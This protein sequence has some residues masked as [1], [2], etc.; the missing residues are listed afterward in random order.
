MRHDTRSRERRRA[1]AP[2]CITRRSRSQAEICTE[3]MY[4][5]EWRITLTLMRPASWSHADLP[6]G[7]AAQESVQPLLQK[8][9]ISLKTQINLIT[10]PVSARMRGAS[11][12]SRLLGWDAVDA[13]APGAQPRSQGGSM[14]PVSG[15]KARQTATLKIA[16]P[17]AV[18]SVRP[19]RWP[20]RTNFA[21]CADARIGETVI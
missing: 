18:E 15:S 5:T 3:L 6:D 16:E 19:A 13:R 14:R 1:D 7:R 17:P 12:S 4:R 21:D 20:R 10:S 9:S 8:D 2:P 11:R